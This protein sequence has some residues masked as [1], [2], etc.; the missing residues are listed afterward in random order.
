MARHLPL[1]LR[2][3]L[4][5]SLR[6]GLRTVRL[7]AG[8][9]QVK[10]AQRVGMGA[11]AYGRYERGSESL[12]PSASTLRRM[13]QQVRASLDELLELEASGLAA[14]PSS[15]R[16]RS[17]RA[18]SRRPGTPSRARRARRLEVVVDLE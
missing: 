17:T 14:R 18:S 2:L 5:D 15:G 12:V 16:H 6:E 10:M 3:Q 11:M 9:S 4:A 1:E 13:Y 7:L 8:L